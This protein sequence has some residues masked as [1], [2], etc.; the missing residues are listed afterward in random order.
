MATSGLSA[1]RPS[2]RTG[3]PATSVR[4]LVGDSGGEARI[5][6]SVPRDLRARF[7]VWAIEHDTTMTDELTRHIR[8]LVE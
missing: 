6:F 8:S 5:N 7:K 2:A 1:G 3:K 4:D